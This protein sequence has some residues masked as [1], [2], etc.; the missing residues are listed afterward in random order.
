[1][2]VSLIVMY[3]GP[4]FWLKLLAPMNIPFMLVT[5][6]TFQAEM[7]PLKEEARANMT[8]MLVTLD[9][10]QAERLPLNEEAP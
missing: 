9:T 10:S 8:F 2:Y 7:S 6:D 3:Q 4:R 1:M 5:L